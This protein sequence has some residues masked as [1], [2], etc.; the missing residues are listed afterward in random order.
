[1]PPRLDNE[2]AKPVNNT[3]GLWTIAGIRYTVDTNLVRY[4]RYD[5]ISECGILYTRSTPVGRSQQA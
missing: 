5:Y 2:V 1:M 4:M 3:N